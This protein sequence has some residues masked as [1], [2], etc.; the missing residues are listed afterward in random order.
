MIFTESMQREAEVGL[1]GP[2]S[3]A[4]DSLLEIDG[5]KIWCS[6]WSNEFMRWAFMKPAADLEELYAQI[7]AGVDI[8]V[9]HQPPYG[10]G[11]QMPADAATQIAAEHVGSQ[12]L[13]AAIDRVKPRVVVCGHIHLGYGSTRTARRASTTCRSS[14]TITG[15]CVER[16][17][18][19]SIS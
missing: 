19:C 13:L 5:L 6:P 2:T 17:K 11:D 16:R 10:Y 3:I 1:P 8:L 14:T 18:S 7:P 15:W 12:Q 4:I 9:S